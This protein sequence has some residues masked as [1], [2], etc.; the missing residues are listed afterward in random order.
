MQKGKM[1]ACSPF[2]L[3]DFSKLVK[4]LEKNSNNINFTF[5][6]V[7][8]CHHHL[9]IIFPIGA[10]YKKLWLLL[11]EISNADTVDE[12]TN[13]LYLFRHYSRLHYV[14]TSKIGCSRERSRKHK[15]YSVLSVHS[16]TTQTDIFETGTVS[17]LGQGLEEGVWITNNGFN[18]HSFTNHGT[19]W[20]LLTN[21]LIGWRTDQ[22]HQWFL[23]VSGQL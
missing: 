11:L 19:F 15:L 18:F 21:H 5:Q 6:D 20:S 4:T 17:I 8:H 16:K 3:Q 14:T 9:D 1:L 7:Y 2:Q 13:L 23:V 10:D 22:V 12:K